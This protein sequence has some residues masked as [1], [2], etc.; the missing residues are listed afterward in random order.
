MSRP[1]DLEMLSD[2]VYVEP[3]VR[4]SSDKK[5]AAG[6]LLSKR[7]HAR[8]RQALRSAQARERLYITPDVTLPR[9]KF[10]E[11]KD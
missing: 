5:I 4:D 2:I 3:P 9:L 10:L 1:T 8:G 6:K 7:V 11:G